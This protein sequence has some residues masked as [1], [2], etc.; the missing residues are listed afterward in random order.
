[1]CVAAFDV[2]S[3]ARN[4]SNLIGNYQ[5]AFREN[6]PLLVKIPPV[7]WAN[8]QYHIDFE[9]KLTYHISSK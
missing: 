4:E 7:F 1:M 8:F 6:T 9:K 3:R 2:R 5:G